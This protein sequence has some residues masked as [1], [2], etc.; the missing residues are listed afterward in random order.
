MTI[1][2]VI[3]V[4]LIIVGIV[5]EIVNKKDYGCSIDCRECPFPPCNDKDKADIERRMKQLEEDIYG[6]MGN[7]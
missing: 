1:L 7:R 5:Y 2:I 4:L 3:A 6:S